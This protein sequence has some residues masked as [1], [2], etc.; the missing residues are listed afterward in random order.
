LINSI[1]PLAVIAGPTAS[2]KSALAA[3]LAR[4]L[5]EQFPEWPAEIVNAD[6]LQLYR[7]MDVGSAK[8]TLDE[9]QEFPHHFFDVRNPDEVFTAGD[10]S[11]LG[12]ELL[13][14]IRARH[15][16]PMLVG[17]AGFYLKALFDGLAPGPGRDEAY[18]HRLLALEKRR[19]GAL[20][21]ALRRVDAAAAAR[22]HRHDGNKLMR[23]L[24][25]IHN[26][27]K[28]LTVVHQAELEKL[29]GFAFLWI[30]LEP[31]RE[32]LR[33]RIADR[34]ERMFAQG[35]VEEV[36]RLRTLGYGPEAKAMESVGYKQVQAHLAGTMTLDEARS[37]VT[38]RTRQYAKRQLTWFRKETA[39]RPIHWL[40]GFGHEEAIQAQAKSLLKQFLTDP[41][42]KTSL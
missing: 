6:S 42:K 16:L 8:P 18:R 39:T 9:R 19:G 4:W 31:E 5:A 1:S 33:A 35:L 2:G 34:T 22:I 41:I 25:V 32:A 26:T 12:R 11:R 13:S 10:Y 20:H 38:L 29:Q 17:G 40:K 14:Q 15:S 23:A 30:G 28:P 21:R 27:Q 7:G 3:A 36:V 24:E 37:D